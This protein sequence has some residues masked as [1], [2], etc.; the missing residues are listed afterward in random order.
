VTHL[1]IAFS[2]RK[3]PDIRQQGRL[4]A[5]RR[6]RTDQRVQGREARRSKKEQGEPRRI[7]EE[8]GKPRRTEEV[9]AF[10]LSGSRKL[11]RRRGLKRSLLSG[12]LALGNSHEVGASLA[13]LAPL[14]S[15]WLPCSPGSSWLLPGF[16]ASLA[17]WRQLRG[18]LASPA[19]WLSWLPGLPGFPGFLG[20][21]P[22]SF[23]L[24]RALPWFPGFPASCWLQR[25]ELGVARTNIL[26][27]PQRA[28]WAFW[29]PGLPNH[30]GS[31]QV[32]GPPGSSL[33]LLASWLLLALLDPPCARWLPAG[34]KG[35]APRGSWL[36]WLS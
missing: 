8:P 30:S 31:P 26:R 33:L 36:P 28:F 1:F 16:L 22:G 4:E 34:F 19:P 14:G 17:S 9:P 29:L 23:C 10:W 32:Q 11:V 5:V 35:T 24:F 2:A 18:S 6:D 7:Q 13:S 12:S 3:H 15:P 20:W 21:V 25:Q 27:P